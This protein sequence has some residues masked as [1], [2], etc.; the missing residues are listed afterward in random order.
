[1]KHDA[2]SLLRIFHSEVQFTG[3][4]AAAGGDNE[5]WCCDDLITVF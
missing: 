5:G 2:A 3:R 4:G 1:M